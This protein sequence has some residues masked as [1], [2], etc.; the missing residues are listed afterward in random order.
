[1]ALATYKDLCIDAVDASR[2]AEFWAGVLRL[3]RQLQDNGDGELRTPDGRVAVW[4]N[5]VAEP[6]TVKNRVH[7]DVDAASVRE[8]LDLGATV[9]AEHPHWTTVSD[10]DG[11]ELC[12]MV[13]DEPIEQR[14]RE[15]V[16]DCAEGPE[17]SH[18][19]AAWWQGV[20]GGRVVDD[21]RGF[22]WVEQIPGAPF[23]SIDF[24]GV[25]E[26]K[27]VKNRVHLDVVTPDVGALLAHGA[28][29]LRGPGGDI[30]WHVLADPDGNEFCAFVE[31]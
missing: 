1:M 24:Q 31:G 14:I 2:A 15:L 7:V 12:V 20:L 25:P 28:T 19:Q 4:V 30:S 23:E 9:V 5:G 10:P 6:R 26:P 17:A 21:E 16:W 29:Q 11:Q 27:T 22:S 13:R 18:A 3:E 8:V